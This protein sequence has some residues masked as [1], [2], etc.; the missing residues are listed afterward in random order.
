MWGVLLLLGVAR[1]PCLPVELGQIS[2]AAA[3][4]PAAPEPAALVQPPPP[5]AAPA[6][7]PSRPAPVATRERT[8]YDVRYGPLS[9][10]E[11]QIQ[12]AG[13]PQGGALVAA[14]GRGAGGL[15]GLGSMENSVATQF[16]LSRLDSRRWVDARSG[17]VR[18]LDDHV[19]QP[20]PGQVAFARELMST[21]AVLRSGATL[22]GPLL[23]PIGLLLRLRVAPPAPGASQV[24]YVL[25]GQALWRVTITSAGRSPFPDP[26]LR[27]P[28][29]R[30]D[31]Q[32]QPIRYDGA[33]ATDPDRQPRT[34][35]LWLSDDAPHVPLRLEMPVGISDVVVSLTDISRS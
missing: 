3:L 11:I 10:G 7:A 17:G 33:P 21:G 9:I 18:A 28:T 30:L 5:A 24:L 23:D 25:D 35:T 6:P 8:R 22:P 29:L 15:L 20:A 32:A 26:S 27:V 31:A 14:V 2:P 19:D 16:D 4:E 13:G 12:V 1:L 34:F